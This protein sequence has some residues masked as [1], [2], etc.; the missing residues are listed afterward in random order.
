[1]YG[2]GGSAVAERV[3]RAL[4][5]SLFDNAVVDA[6]AERTGMTRAEASARDERVPSM[7]E[8]LATTLSLGTPESLPVVP[9]QP[10]LMTEERIVAITRRIIEEAVQ[11]GPAVLVGRGAQCLLASRRDA[12]H[13][14]CYASPPML[15]EGAVLRLGV[16]PKEA[17][18][19]VAEM[20]RNR[21]QYVRRHFHREW[22]DVTNYHL[23]LDTGWHGLDG[24]AQ[25]VVEAARRHFSLTR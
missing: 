12:L 7:V 15:I 20:N 4:G 22:R 2:A 19:V 11:Q 5:W 3:A 24:A 23:C 18:R 9:Q 25:I 21:E 17:E 1:M 8:R 14:F 13:V 6:V 16:A 10:V